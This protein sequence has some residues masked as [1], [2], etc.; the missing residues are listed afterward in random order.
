MTH[1][2]FLNIV[3]VVVIANFIAQVPYLIHQYHGKPSAIGIILMTVVLMWFLTGYTLLLKQKM[4]GYIILI[5]FLIV[6]FLFYLSNQVTQLASGKGILL[7]VLH[8]DDALLFVV[9]GLGY[10][11]FIAAGYFVFYLL[12]Y[13]H[14]FI[15]TVK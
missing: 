8:P 7:H 15:N 14:I 2:Q 9:F 12:R 10:I 3:F 4:A 13:K 1:K 6:E 11:N 5:T